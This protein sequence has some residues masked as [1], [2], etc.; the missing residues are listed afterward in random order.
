MVL[1]GSV[2]T[3][4]PVETPGFLFISQP[5][6]PR[7]Q[8]FHIKRINYRFTIDQVVA[9]ITFFFSLKDRWH[10]GMSLS[11]IGRALKNDLVR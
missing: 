7:H 3:D 6:P 8:R 5:I 2:R 9:P 1:L 4:A 11:S 10:R